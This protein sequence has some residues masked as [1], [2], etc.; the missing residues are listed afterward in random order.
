MNINSMRTKFMLPIVALAVASLMMSVAVALIFQDTLQEKF[1]EKA[2]IIGANIKLNVDD[3]Q[4]LGFLTLPELNEISNIVPR[5]ISDAQAR[6][7]SYWAILT[8][9]AKVIF[10]GRLEEGAD[11]RIVASDDRAILQVMEKNPDLR[12]KFVERALAKGE[13]ESRIE[14][15]V[16]VLHDDDTD[17][18]YLNIRFTL[19]DPTSDDPIG[20]LVLGIP[21][22]LINAEIMPIWYAAGV[23]VLVAAMI[24]V[25]VGVMQNRVVGRPIEGMVSLATRIA[26]GDLTYRTEEMSDDEIGQLSQSLNGMAMRIQEIF[27]EMLTATEQLATSAQNF[28]DGIKNM[29]GNSESQFAKT[30]EMTVAIEEMAASVQLVYENSQ[31]TRELATSA[32]NSATKGGEVVAQT[33]RSM[34]SVERIVTE[35]AST[36]R[37]LGARSEEIGKIIDVIKEISGQTNLLALNAAIEAARAGEH[38]RGFEVVAE[39]V[40][41]L[42]EKSRQST[43]QITAIIG[44]IT[45]DTNQAVIVM[46]SATREVSDGAGH[47][48]RTREVLDEIVASNANVLDMTNAMAEAAQQQSRVSDEVAVAV[49]DI[50]RAAK[51][52]SDQAEE[53]AHTV[54]NLFELAENVRNMVGRFRI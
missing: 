44:D 29:A 3:L 33:Q 10:Y 42:A 37:E 2:Q 43:L 35:S 51:D 38:G 54:E 23:F 45:D 36:I 47:A 52:V 18:D 34:Q 28:S 17:E 14:D 13:S 25:F 15:E 20:A 7:I 21:E 46:E 48:N 32:N 19:T 26:D 8:P 4:R 24:A 40:R 6:D 9:D 27:R 16:I 12:K 41:K 49:T 39:E 5:I 1:R 22:R 53:L 30:K 11:G 31:R 50:S